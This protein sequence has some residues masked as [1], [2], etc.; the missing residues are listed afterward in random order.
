[1]CIEG[2]GSEGA[3]G[4]GGG[5]AGG[6]GTGGRGWFFADTVFDSQLSGRGGATGSTVGRSRGDQG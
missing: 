5:P 6:E 4:T 3:G 1:M 2:G